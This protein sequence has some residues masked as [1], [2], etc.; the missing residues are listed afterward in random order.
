MKTLRVWPKS[1]QVCDGGVRW[2]SAVECD[3]SVMKLD[4]ETMK[5]VHLSTYDIKGGAA[6]ATYR[7]HKEPERLGHQSSMFVVTRSSHDTAVVEFAPAT[8]LMSRL[9]R[10]FRGK[11]IARDFA[12]YQASRPPGYE[13]FSDDRSR[14]AGEFLA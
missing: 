5:V 7:L 8:N 9:Q 2:R 1:P 11:R 4:G 14:Y 12:P 10:W 3:Y 13:P 6:Q